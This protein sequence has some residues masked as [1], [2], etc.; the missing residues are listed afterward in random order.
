MENEFPLN[1][2]SHQTWVSSIDTDSRDE[3]VPWPLLIVRRLVCFLLSFIFEVWT[4]V[5]FS[6]EEIGALF[7]FLLLNFSKL[8]SLVVIFLDTLEEA[9][10]DSNQ[11]SISFLL[12]ELLFHRIIN[13]LLSISWIQGLKNRPK[14]SSRRKIIWKVVRKVCLQTRILFQ[15][16]TINILHQ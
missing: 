13:Q 8:T 10:A 16:P 9:R 2:N 14:E 5:A 15:C 11:F 12:P 6:P 3:E 1:Q 7:L 4:Q